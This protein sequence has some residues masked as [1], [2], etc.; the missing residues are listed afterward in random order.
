MARTAACARSA[1]P[2][3]TYYTVKVDLGGVRAEAQATAISGCAALA[4][5]P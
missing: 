1:A 4:N 2:S 3:S 5:S